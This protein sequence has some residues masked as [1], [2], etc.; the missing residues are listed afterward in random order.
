MGFP[1]EWRPAFLREAGRKERTLVGDALGK[2]LGTLLA[3][4]PAADLRAA[5]L[6][7]DA[8]PAEG[9]VLRVVWRC[10]VCGHEDTTAPG[11]HGAALALLQQPCAACGEGP[12][13]LAGRIIVRRFV[14][15]EAMP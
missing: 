1:T 8:L 12:V 4:L 3:S 7:G 9:R 14:P 6:A 10:A 2:P 15:E 5:I 11:D 13:Q